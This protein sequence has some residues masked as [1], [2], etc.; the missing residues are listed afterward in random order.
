MCSTLLLSKLLVTTSIVTEI[1]SFRF[2][3]PVLAVGLGAGGVQ[4][5][6]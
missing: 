4:L 6:F 3:G 2:H 1:R 5:T